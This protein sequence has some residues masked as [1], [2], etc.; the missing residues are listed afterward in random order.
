LIFTNVI[1]LAINYNFSNGNLQRLLQ[2]NK[3]VKIESV[4]FAVNLGVATFYCGKQ[5]NRRWR[6]FFCCLRT[7]S[8]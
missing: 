8:F 6:T 3:V 4:I 2:G 1:N 7:L 5:E